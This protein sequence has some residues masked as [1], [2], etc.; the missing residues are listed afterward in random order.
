MWHFN[1]FEYGFE[2]LTRL[3]FLY[4]HNQAMI[5]WWQNS[6]Q[7]KEIGNFNIRIYPFLEVTRATSGSWNIPWIGSIKSIRRLKKIHEWSKLQGSFD[8][9]KVVG[10]KNQILSVSGDI[11][12]YPRGLTDFCGRN[13]LSEKGVGAAAPTAPTLMQPLNWYHPPLSIIQTTKYKKLLDFNYER[14]IYM[15][16][17]YEFFTF[18]EWNLATLIF[19][20]IGKKP[21]KVK[22]KSNKHISFFS[23]KPCYPHLTSISM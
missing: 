21:T 19:N 8:S 17:E 3:Y 5:F 11:P 12:K 15:G 22:R 18:L 2:S 16:L 4:I 1:L 13:T 10:A 23:G 9:L 7:K 6:V 20:E 14:F